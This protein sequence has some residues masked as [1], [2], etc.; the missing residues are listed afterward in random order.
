MFSTISQ[1][2]EIPQ[3]YD[4]IAGM[5]IIES[6]SEEQVPLVRSQQEI[7]ADMRAA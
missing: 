7:S 4:G 3:Q 5:R 6:K 1:N 2:R